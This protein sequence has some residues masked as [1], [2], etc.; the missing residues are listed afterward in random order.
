MTVLR[1]R[2]VGSITQEHSPKS[3]VE[4]EPLTPEKEVESTSNKS[5]H[6]NT[7]KS[8]KIG[9]AD[10][11]N[12][13]SIL[14]QGL[15]RSSRLS[16]NSNLNNAVESV[17]SR[18]KRKV[19]H[20]DGIEKE[21]G[22]VRVSRELDT[23]GGFEANVVNKKYDK[24]DV[25][26]VRKIKSRRVSS[27]DVEESCSGSVQEGD[28]GKRCSSLRSGKKL[29][30]AK[31]NNPDCDIMLSANKSEME[32]EER[33]GE[34]NLNGVSERVSGLIVEESCSESV[35]DGDV[36]NRSLSLRSRKKLSK[37]KVN[38]PDYDIKLLAN[39]CEMETEE[40]GG[41]ANL[42]GVSER[43]S[44][45]VVEESCSESVQDGDVGYRSLSLRSRKNFIKSEVH[46]P[47]GDIELSANKNE[48]ET[49]FSG[50]SEKVVVI[51]EERVAVDCKEMDIDLGN[52]GNG[53]VKRDISR[54]SIEEKGKGKVAEV[55]SASD[56]GDADDLP[57]KP[58]EGSLMETTVADTVIPEEKT[59]VG[60][61]PSNKMDPKERFKNVAKENASRFAHFS[62][63]EEDVDED[64]VEAPMEA[65][66]DVEDW[67]G[68]FSTAMK[69]IKDRA[70]NMPA[71]QKKKSD[72]TPLI[73]NPKKNNQHRRFMKVVPS[74]QELCMEIMA[75]NVE[76]ITSL[77]RV[78]DV[79]RHKLTQALCDSRKMNHH[80]FNLL[81]SNSP[82]EIRV[83]D[84]SWLT[85]DQFTKTF[86]ETDASILTVLQLDQ[87]GR[88]LP[89]YVL[90]STLS[91]L[92]SKF[93]ALT[94]VSLKGACRLSDAGLNALVT[95]A[96]AL[97][98]INLGC[99]SLLTSEGIINLADKLGS[100]LKELYIDECF[101][102]DAKSI[103][104]A[105]CKLQHLEVL[106]ISRFDTVNDSFIIQLVAVQGHKMKELVVSDC[107]KLTDKAL[108]FIAK[109]CPGLCA[110]DLR[111]LC[112]L[113]DASLGH[114]ANGCQTIQTLK[115]CRNA[116]SDE[117]LAAY[118]EA[119]GGPLT[120]LSLN[121]VDKVAHQ[122]ALSLAKHAKKLQC[123]DL[124]WCRE[125]TD[126]CVGLIVDSCLSLEMLKLFGCTQITNVF[127]EGHSNEN[128][129]IIGLQESQILKNIVVPDLLPLRY[130]SV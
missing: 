1:S 77:E 98:S 78:P 27:L 115:L 19:V 20:L 118:V 96:C 72:S 129:R 113:T 29:S 40:R 76:A 64:E 68:P 103:L 88:C 61:G 87:C 108:K 86:E 80:F 73:W 112:K 47:A 130:S 52:G 122:T 82:S 32:T 53:T 3:G 89:D 24:E 74:L 119:C 35:Q 94:N 26:S 30:K 23:S 91:H 85:E 13:G 121:H 9:S 28:V 8:K 111:N 83:K 84:C 58:E 116:F 60:A 17:G 41:E 67:P 106:S 55:N 31:V 5:S 125:M 46:N 36:G 69:I 65:N 57:G 114:L 75:E 50:V 21:S 71:E 128:V 34:S 70:S 12:S 6:E 18:G 127:T 62:I 51:E 56:I 66:G 15:R 81:A 59:I 38:N 92:P 79:I 117:A 110:I 126:E 14:I 25:Q 124:S 4:I 39:K 107:T 95:S 48:K 99:C 120:E 45:L 11:I 43:V 37:A 49:D 22:G 109:G 16:S 10:A 123:L 104:P 90:Y 7:P 33:G 44:S 2:K 42:N 97:R 100:V 102:I 54:F 101:G 105:L 93:S 63:Q